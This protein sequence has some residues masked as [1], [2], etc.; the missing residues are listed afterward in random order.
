MLLCSFSLIKILRKK[1]FL[2]TDWEFG[3]YEQT[4]V[5]N[6]IICEKGEREVKKGVFT[7]QC[8]LN[9]SE[10]KKRLS[11]K[12]ERWGFI[13]K[14]KRS[15]LF[16]A[17]CRGACETPPWD[18][19]TRERRKVEGFLWPKCSEVDTSGDEQT[20]NRRLSTYSHCSP[21]HSN[22]LERRRQETSEG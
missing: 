6:K 17:G 19:K 8:C 18:K 14:I 9:S 10:E 11:G 3:Y 16:G 15:F 7:Q 5:I 22:T 4:H 20:A 13:N 21:T 12:E 2:D 1:F